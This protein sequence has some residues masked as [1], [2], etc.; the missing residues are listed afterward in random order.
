MDCIL[1]QPGICRNIATGEILPKRRFI[2]QN[3]TKCDD[4]Y[5][6]K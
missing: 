4:R 6:P 2:R 1:R 5:N 3:Q